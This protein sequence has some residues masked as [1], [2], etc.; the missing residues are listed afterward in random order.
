MSGNACSA[1]TMAHPMRWVKLTLPPT[2][3]RISWLLRIL[4]LTSSSFAGNVRTDVA[5]GSSS[6]SSIRSA[7]VAAPPRSGIATPPA[8]SSG[9]AASSAWGAA[10]GAAAAAA[11]GCGAGGAGG[12]GWGGEAVWGA[13]AASAISSGAGGGGEN[14]AGAAGAAGATSVSG[15]G[16]AAKY[17][18]HESLTDSGSS[19]NRRYIWSTSH[20]FDPKSSSASAIGGA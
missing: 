3:R 4:R 13:E 8:G 18:R 17:S 14:S 11:A 5:V 20:A 6:D 1:R 9:A 2:A 7:I 19:R 12:A 15:G 16:P 10:C